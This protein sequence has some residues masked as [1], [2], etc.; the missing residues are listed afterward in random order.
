MMVSFSR[1]LAQYGDER[2]GLGVRAV[3]NSAAQ[4]PSEGARGV[5]Q[6][7]AGAAKKTNVSVVV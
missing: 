7:H 3:P 2:K 4:P 5:Y 6:I 1:V